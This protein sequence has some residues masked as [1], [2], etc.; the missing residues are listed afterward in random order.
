MKSPT[1]TIV[2]ELPVDQ[3]PEL[4][5]KVEKKSGKRVGYNYIIIK[6][7]K[8]SQKNDVV[9]CLY[10]KSLTNF[11]F[12][13]IKEG[14]YGDTKD[15][16][17]RD[18]I[19][20]L[21]WQQQLHQ[22]LH[23]KIRMP[24]LL[25]HFE[26]RGNYYLVIEHIKGKALQKVCAEN[27]KELRQS[28][29][30]GGKLGMRFLDYLIQI[31][32]ILETLHAEQIVHR[33]ATPNNYM[34]LPNGKVILIDMELSYSLAQQ[35]PS[36]AFQLGTYGYMSKQQEATLTPTPSEDTFALGAIM[37]QIWSGI[38]PGKLVNEP[39]D[40]LIKKID[41]FI[42]DRQMADLVTQCLLPEDDRRPNA[43]QIRQ[44]LQR[45][46][47]DFKYKIARPITSPEKLLREE[48]M[49]T[50]QD[51]I[52]TLSTPLFADE[53]KGWFFDDMKP[54]PQEDKHRLRKK[55]YASYNRGV[56]G[57]IYMLAQAKRVGLDVTATIPFVE[58]GLDLINHKYITRSKNA[59]TG[60]HFGSDGIAVALAAAF[61]ER[62]IDPS[63]EYLNWIDLLLQKPNKDND[64]TNGIAGQGVA[65]L[66]CGTFLSRNPMLERLSGYAEKLV[67]QQHPDG[68]W[69][70]G[71]LR[72]KYLRKRKKKVTRGYAE[73][74]A[75]IIYFL[76]E[77]GH[78][79]NHQPSISAAKRGLQWLIKKSKSRNNTVRW[80]SSRGQELNDGLSDG[81]SGI[82][83]TFI[84]A[85]QF[86]GE[87]IY[88]QYAINTLRGI[89][90]KIT[91]GNIGQRGGLAGLGEA[92][93]EAYLILKDETWLQRAGWIAQVIM[94]LKK[95]HPTH[96]PYWLVEQERHPT[97]SFM[98]GNSGVMHF[99]LRYCNPKKINFPLMIH[100]DS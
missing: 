8:E 97:A 20:R 74:M 1:I 43:T 25:S 95:Q 62:L 23:G 11:G 93:V 29:I 4:K 14:S 40:T 39:V 92:Y 26:E 55:W 91:D 77:Y 96:G 27:R 64:I 38:S 68:C 57:V 89:P 60:L 35:Y 18:I 99:L 49:S 45:C 82:A 54:P 71:Y 86:T 83:L 70:N 16:H 61:R 44:T 36:P 9:K 50:V 58:K 47:T 78:R 41:F 67:S 31:A 33:D 48:I 84:K 34:I 53:Y 98:T 7:Y 56:S 73:G 72:G 19:D 63:A 2:S 88:R 24:K 66:A 37:F 28:I 22:Q 94:Y 81:L 13:V 32:G 52:L 10:I 21:K 51:T 80:L 87:A 15:K 17:G 65:N 46:K 75:G 69:I 42:P 3:Q 30:K 79:N 5:G 85:Y 100:S 59:A 90:E 12:C 76:L 6:S